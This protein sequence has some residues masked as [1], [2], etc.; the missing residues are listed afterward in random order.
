MSTYLFIGMLSPKGRR[1]SIASI[2][3]TEREE[4]KAWQSRVAVVGVSAMLVNK[5]VQTTV[6]GTVVVSLQQMRVL[7]RAL[8]LPLSRARCVCACLLCTQTHTVL[9]IRRQGHILRYLFDRRRVMLPAATS[10]S[11]TP[12][13]D[14]AAVTLYRSIFGGIAP[15]LDHALRPFLDT[16]PP[17]IAPSKRTRSTTTLLIN[18]CGRSGTHALVAL[19]RRQGISALH[20]GHGR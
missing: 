13:P 11:P 1:K 15:G 4:T 12:R 17:N 7:R 9:Y 3:A 19:L 10:H 14:S 8:A 6:P 18:G 5:V 20:E 16:R 2:T